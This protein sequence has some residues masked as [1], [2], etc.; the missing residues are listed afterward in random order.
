LALTAIAGI[1]QGIAIYKDAK[2][3]GS[4]LY[5]VTKEISGFIGQFF[6]A[7]EEVKK[8]VKR[9]ELNPP[10][11]KSLKAQA[12]ENV[13]NQIELERQSVELREF[14]IYHTDPALGAVWSRY[15]AEYAKLAKKHEEEIKQEVIAERKRKWQR[16]KRLDK[17]ADEALIFGATLIVILEIW[18][19]MYLIHR[20]REI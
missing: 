8:E 9:Q 2:A 6:E 18:A 4:D 13:F 14:L 1:K 3:T 10:K 15:E 20:S 12:L 11:E 7:H 19:L 16:Q 17:L 5:K